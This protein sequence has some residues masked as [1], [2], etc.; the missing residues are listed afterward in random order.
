MYILQVDCTNALPSG[1]VRVPSNGNVEDVTGRS[2][3]KTD[4]ASYSE[5]SAYSYHTN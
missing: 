4:A 5:T 1:M 3:L 2:D